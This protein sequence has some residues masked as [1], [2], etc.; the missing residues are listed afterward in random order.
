MLK[1]FKELIDTYAS[2]EITMEDLQSIQKVG[3]VSFN[4]T[5]IARSNKDCLLCIVTYDKLFEFKNKLLAKTLNSYDEY[6]DFILTS[7]F[8][9]L[10]DKDVSLECTSFKDEEEF[11]EIHLSVDKNGQIEFE[12][13]DIEI[14]T[15]FNVYL[16]I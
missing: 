12:S 8:G 5:G 4:N 10:R 3:F 7:G 11:F 1:K 6:E 13:E 9:F 2:K 16:R 14:V 15:S